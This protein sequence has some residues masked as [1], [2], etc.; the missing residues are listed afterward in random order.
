[1]NLIPCCDAMKK[2]LR[3]GE[4]NSCGWVFDATLGWAYTTERNRYV[5]YGLH[6]CPYCGKE[7]RGAFK[8]REYGALGDLQ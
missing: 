1:M 3:F 2:D 4:D 6:Y 8:K 7:M 5:L